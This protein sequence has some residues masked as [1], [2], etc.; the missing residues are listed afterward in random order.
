MRLPPATRMVNLHPIHLIALNG[1]PT[2]VLPWYW[3]PLISVSIYTAKP[4][5][6]TVDGLFPYF[7]RRYGVKLNTEILSLPLPRE[8]EQTFRRWAE[9]EMALR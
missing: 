2:S 4:R 1:W 8:F 3:A 6:S 9:G 5:P 7:A